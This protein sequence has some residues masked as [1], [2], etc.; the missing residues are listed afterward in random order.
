MFYGAF[1]ADDQQ[2][3]AECHDLPGNEKLQEVGSCNQHPKTCIHH[4][5]SRIKP[6]TFAFLSE[7]RYHCQNASNDE[8]QCKKES[9]IILTKVL[10]CEQPGVCTHSANCDD[11][12][13][14][15]GQKFQNKHKC[16]KCQ[17]QVLHHAVGI[18]M[19]EIKVNA[20]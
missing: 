18:I 10:V 7:T 2:V 5:G 19:I 11:V 6:N 3:G 8:N 1:S 13:Q 20:G 12:F 14:D 16:N 9:E 15:G 4:H 17:W